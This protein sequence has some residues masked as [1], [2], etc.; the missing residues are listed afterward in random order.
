MADGAALGRR[1]VLKAVPLQVGGRWIS[2]SAIVA[3]G[4]R[5]QRFGAGRPKQ[6]VDIGGRSLLDWSLQALLQHPAVDEVIVALPAA[7]VAQPPSSLR[8]GSKPVR[9]VAGGARR[10]DSVANAFAAADPRADVILIHDAARPFVSAELIARSVAAAVEFGAAVAAVPSRDTVKLTD[11]TGR[12]LETLPR[13]RIYLAQTPQ[14]FR[15]EI[16]RQAFALAPPEEEATDEATLAERA[17]FTVRVVEGDASNIKIT[18]PEDMPMAEALIEARAP[19]AVPD[20]GWRVGT[21][22]DL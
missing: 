11:A 7:V 16:L 14:T 21:G 5:G 8:T 19:V 9:L 10:Q 4:G 17:G 13:E 3:A 12:V 15:R 2:T 18:V 20:P 1:A 6:L 22:Y